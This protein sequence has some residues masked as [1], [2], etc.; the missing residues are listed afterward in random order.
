MI[1]TRPS[2]ANSSKARQAVQKKL[3]T[4]NSLLRQPQTREQLND[5]ET[6]AY[7]ARQAEK[8]AKA[9]KRHSMPHQAQYTSADASET[10]LGPL[11]ASSAVLGS[12]SFTLSPEST[13]AVSTAFC[14]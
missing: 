4:S 13:V 12:A 8:Q 7:V 6:Q 2:T 3:Q 10:E 11:P 9:R 5:I 1:N 14:D